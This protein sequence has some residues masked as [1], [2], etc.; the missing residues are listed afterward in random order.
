VQ[1]HPA[2]RYKDR[3]RIGHKDYPLVV[4]RV[5]RSPFNGDE[6]KA[7][8]IYY[9]DEVGLWREVVNEEDRLNLAR[10]VEEGRLSLVEPIQWPR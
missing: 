7:D 8:A 6:R 3:L 9:D 10:A 5:V 2:T 1:S 4:K